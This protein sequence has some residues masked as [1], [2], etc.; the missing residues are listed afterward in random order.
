VSNNRRLEQK[1]L[2]LEKAKTELDAASK[3][4]SGTRDL[5]VDAMVRLRDAQYCRDGGLLTSEDQD[6]LNEIGT[7][8][9]AARSQFFRAR[10]RLAGA[11]QRVADLDAGLDRLQKE[12]LADRQRA[13]L[14]KTQPHIVAELD[15]A[16]SV[17]SELYND[18][19][20]GTTGH[21]QRVL[22]AEARRNRAQEAYDV[23]CLEFKS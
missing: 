23:A 2:D 18:R 17:C 5:A 15:D 13:W 21:A 9:N 7:N 16:Q 4:Y 14:L 22:L 12:D 1:V 6:Y 10:Q 11:R 20:Q 8:A 3:T 19:A